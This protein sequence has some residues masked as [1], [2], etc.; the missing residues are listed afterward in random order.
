M[1]IEVIDHPCAAVARQRRLDDASNERCKCS[2]MLAFCG[3]YGL[4]VPHD[5]LNTDKS[6]TKLCSELNRVD[7][8]PSTPLNRTVNYV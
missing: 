5:N 2:R 1:T 4:Q 6:A 8:N 7:I 3:F